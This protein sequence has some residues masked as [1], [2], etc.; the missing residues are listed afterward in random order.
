MSIDGGGGGG[1]GGVGG[2][3]EGRKERGHGHDRCERAREGYKCK[4][5]VLA[6]ARHGDKGGWVWFHES[7]VSFMS[8][9]ICDKD[10]T[11][12]MRGWRR[13]IDSFDICIRRDSILRARQF[14]L[15]FVG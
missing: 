7:E 2:G 9:Y 13:E 12:S 8:G 11:D 6:G 10:M 5:S 15:L 3:E 14:L 4:W 1:G